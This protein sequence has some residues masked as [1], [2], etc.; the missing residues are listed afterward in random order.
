[1]KKRFL[2]A[3]VAAASGLCLLPATSAAAQLEGGVKVGVNI[4]FVHGP[5]L[6]Y[7]P[8]LGSSWLMRF[9]LCGGGFVALPLSKIVAVQAE[10]LITTK[11]SHESGTLFGDDE[12]PLYSLKV[13]YLE[14]PLLLRAM[15]SPRKIG[16]FVLAGPALDLRL[17]TRLLRGSEA[18]PFSGVK[19]TDLG[20]VFAAGAVTFFG[21]WFELRYTAGMSKI[22]EEGGVPL[23][24]KNGVF[25]L[26]A[27]YRF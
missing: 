4:A 17:G 7:F 25:S 24:I 12:L 14:I 26:I 18:I 27:G 9:G 2:I 23:N 6:E 8:Y 11:G 16:I 15:T 10:A 20:F 21:S 5:D 22:I 19:S 3:I 13:T 1:M